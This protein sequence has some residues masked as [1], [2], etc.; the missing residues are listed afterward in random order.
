MAHTPGAAIR[1]E[2]SARV[3]IENSGWISGLRGETIAG[4]L[5]S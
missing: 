1:R 4:A 2:V 5:Y 3:K